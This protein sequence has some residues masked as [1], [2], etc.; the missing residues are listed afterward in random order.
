MVPVKGEVRGQ[1]SVALTPGRSPKRALA[2]SAKTVRS[3]CSAWAA[4]IRS[5][6]PR[7]APV[8]R[9][10]AISLAWQAAVAR[11]SRARR[12]RR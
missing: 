3:A 8:R 6:A 2:L 10:C 11:R 1:A 5:C 9:A 12:R 7:A 4:M